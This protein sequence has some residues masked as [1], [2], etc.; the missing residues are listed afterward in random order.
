MRH[1][2][3][4]PL[5]TDLYE[6]TMLQA[7]HHRGMNELAVFEL[8]VRR[9]PGRNFLV[10]AGLEQVLDFL[11]QLRFAPEDL[12]WLREDARFSPA[13]ID[14]LAS[15]RFTGE[16]DAVP[17]GTLCFPDEPLI[18]ITAPLREA[19]LIESR[20]MNLMHFQTLV[21][22]K[23]VRCT[24]AAGGRTL[25]D[26]GMRRAHGAEA[27]LLAARACYL[28]GFEAT[29]TAAA[30]PRFGIPVA[31]TMA[32]S[33]VQAFGDETSAFSAFVE[34]FPAEATLLIDTYDSEAGAERVVQLVRWLRQQ[35]RSGVRAVRIDSGDLGPLACR[36]RQ[37]LDRGGC[38]E[39]GIFASGNL[40]EF[41][42]QGLVDGAAPIDGFGVG[43]RVS[44]A[45]D[46]PYLDCAYKLV[47]YA[48]QASRKRSTGKATW[49]GR[50]QVY[51]RAD[52]QGRWAGDIVTLRGDPQDGAGL[53]QP[54]MRGGR[55]LAASPGLAAIRA[56]VAQQLDA[57]PAPL[58]SLAP[59]APY[60]VAV[61]TALHTLA[62]Q[63]DARQH[64]LAAQE[65]A[66]WEG[67]SE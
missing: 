9:H 48:G 34:A 16:V 46:A 19:Q 20:L 56:H 54:V 41:A 44:T 65:T 30:A 33:F 29:A 57:L 52:A 5:L 45:A 4:S 3:E 64:A 1:Y 66:S 42:L 10:A 12:A 37:V 31:G 51:R 22:S 38:P 17:E 59:A 8:F 58:R 32:H 62:Q 6:L 39:V 53:L 25:V 2:S 23:A 28:A 61:S 50:K 40:D 11:E 14:S 67:D 18:Q 21:A 15:L 7:Y 24:L 35:G 49:P 55:R 13:F 27:A 36:V 63:T 47:E 43:S 26:F 60:P